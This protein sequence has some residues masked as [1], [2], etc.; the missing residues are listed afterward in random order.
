MCS[1]H[2]VCKCMNNEVYKH[3]KYRG[4]AGVEL[5]WRYGF[6][7]SVN[8]HQK[9]YSYASG[10]TVCVVQGALGV[11]IVG[12]T[13]LPSMHFTSPLRTHGDPSRR[14]LSTPCASVP[15]T[16]T[17]GIWVFTSAI[18]G[19]STYPVSLD[20]SISTALHF[21]PRGFF[22]KALKGGISSFDSVSKSSS[23]YCADHAHWLP[24]IFSKCA[25][26]DKGPTADS[27]LTVS[28]LRMADAGYKV[29]AKSC[30]RTALRQWCNSSLAFSQISPHLTLDCRVAS[31]ATPGRIWSRSWGSQMSQQATLGSEMMA[32]HSVDIVSLWDSESWL[33]YLVFSCGTLE[34]ELLNL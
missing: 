15:L 10:G 3:Y 18:F 8:G 33:A 22:G 7:W 6:I 30:W 34:W 1:A 9:Q 11:T 13:S 26:L 23:P 14:R 27:K 32:S 21:V 20:S 28:S 29:P 25:R 17:A 16:P 2:L 19:F 5:G 12:T 24:R 31:G 4:F